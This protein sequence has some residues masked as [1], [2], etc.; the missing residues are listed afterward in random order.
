MTPVLWI[1]GR[2]VAKL[3]PLLGRAIQHD[4]R[5]CPIDNLPLEKWEHD[6]T[7]YMQILC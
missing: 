1:R 3:D 6:K 7:E 4:I 5:S 2:P